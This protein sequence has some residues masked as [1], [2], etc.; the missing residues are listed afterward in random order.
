MN[1][2]KH[3]EN[4]YSINIVVAAETGAS[5]VVI[6]FADRTPYSELHTNQ[7]IEQSTLE[8][9]MYLPQ[10]SLMEHH[11]IQEI[12]TTEQSL[13]YPLDILDKKLVL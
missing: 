13:N 8:N 2:N 3:F 11:A 12:M 5:A 7:I 1:D 4:A 10:L 9:L 6:S